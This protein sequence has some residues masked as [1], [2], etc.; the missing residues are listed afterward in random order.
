MPSRF[1]RRVAALILLV[2]IPA[3]RAEADDWGAYAIVPASAP[4]LTLEAVDA[5]SVG[6]AVVSIGR[7]NHGPAQKWTITP[8]EGD[9]YLIRPAHAPRL[10][11][12][13]AEGGTKMGTPIVL[14]ADRGKPWQRW[15]LSKN[16]DGSYCLIPAHARG[17]GLDHLGGDPRPGAKIDLWEN[18][19]GDRH[20]QWFVRPLAGSPAVAVGVGGVPETPPSTYTPPELKP[21]QVKAGRV[22]QFTFATSSIY[23]GT[24]RQVHV[25]IP[26]QYDGSKPA[27]VSVKFDGY[28]PAEK[29]ILEAMIAAGELPVTV[30]IFV[31]PGDLA[32]PVK[33]TIGRRNRCLEYDAVGDA[34]ARFLVDEVLPEVA[35]RF[36]LKL[37]ASGNDRSISG[38]SSGGIAAFNAAFHR[39]DLFSRVYANSG[40][41]V[42]FRGGHEFPTLVRKFEPRPIRAYLTTGMRDMEN[43][44]G[45][46]FLLDLEMDKSLKFSGYD[47]RFRVINGGHVAGYYD[48]FREAMAYVWKDWPK[49]VEP[50]PGAPRVRDLILP[51]EPWRLVAEG[52]HDVRAGAGNERGEVTFVDPSAGAIRKIDIDGSISDFIPDAG[53][54]D[55][56]SYGPRGELYAVSGRTGKVVRF[57]GSGSGSVV[58]ADGLFARHVLAMPEGGLFV[59]GR[60]SGEDR[61]SVWFVRDGRKARVDSAPKSAGGLAYR[62]DRWLLAVADGRSKWAFSYRIKPDGSLADRE[63]FFWLHV[64]DWEDDAGAE[65][66]C[67]AREGQLLIATRFGVQSCADDG[68]S[69]VILPL[70]GRARPLGLCF[71]GRE[72][73]VLY[74]FCG[75]RI[76]R[77]KLRVHGVGAWTPFTPVRATPL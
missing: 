5:R 24:T 6:G 49:P 2:V 37:S 51:G 58:V 76:Y 25:F 61:D 64:P 3:A 22:E 66:A 32:S 39:P 29:P 12:A 16:E 15:S 18:R 36:D 74:A 1:A 14:E 67:Y 57:E 46:W 19:P 77:R 48:C 47:Y 9:T 26:A 27:C 71:G 34:N 21:G 75:D 45:D 73:D 13:V 54:A 56:L 40:S 55:G 65:G 33:G 4:G 28:N 17:M 53:Q 69:Q 35:R 31:R 11:L 7:P 30:G 59:A 60:A 68:P 62:P 38:G 42:A 70:P 10:V 41:F 44:A 20:L 52:L 43:A 50:G 8:G 72:H 63:R 23:P